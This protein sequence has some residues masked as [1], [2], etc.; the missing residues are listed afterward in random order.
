MKIILQL[1]REGRF[2]TKVRFTL[3]QASFFVVLLLV[4]KRWQLFIDV[5]KIGN[6]MI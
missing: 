2:V 5:N 4:L 1:S 6:N 3:L